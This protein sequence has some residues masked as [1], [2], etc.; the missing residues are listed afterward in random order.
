MTETLHYPDS[1]RMQLRGNW[2]YE[3]FFADPVG[4]KGGPHGAVSTLVYCL[5]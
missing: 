3:K 4:P 1:R 2:L 5:I